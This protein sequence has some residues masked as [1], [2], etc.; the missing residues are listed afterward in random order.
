LEIIK[1]ESGTGLRIDLKGL[2][3]PIKEI[4]NL[5]LEMWSKHRHKR[6]DEI[7]DHNRALASSIHLLEE[8]G[9]KVKKGNLTDEDGN[10][11]KRAVVASALGLFKNGALIEE[12]PPVESID[13]V[14]LL[15]GFGP[16]LLAAPP[17]E[18]ADEGRLDAQV[19][20]AVSIE[21]P[22]RHRKSRTKRK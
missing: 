4:K 12:I 22:Q 1:L 20:G 11:F 16:K 19:P 8:I 21:P 9:R 18:A 17:E 14:K 7:V 5:I 6:V 13:N 2:G 3:E 10:R 15:D